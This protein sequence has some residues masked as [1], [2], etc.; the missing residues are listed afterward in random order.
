LSWPRRLRG[1][2]TA[3][4]IDGDEKRMSAVARP[5]ER[6]RGSSLY[7]VGALLS[8]SSY[9]YLV[10]LGICPGD[11]VPLRLPST[12]F[13]RQRQAKIEFKRH[14]PRGECLAKRR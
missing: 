11:A 2:I 14:R 12:L 6:E 5:Q 10:L 4:F 1:F 9:L 3:I 13:G 8:W 7:M